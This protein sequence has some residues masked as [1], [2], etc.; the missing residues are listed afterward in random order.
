[1]RV[2]IAPDKFKGSLTA[3]EAAGAMEHGVR[4][5]CA[6][7]GVEV[8]IDVCPMADGGDGT[9]EVVQS[10][11]SMSERVAAR[12]T[13]P[14]PGH[15]ADVEWLRW[16]DETGRR[17]GLVE[18]AKIVGLARVPEEHRDP[19]RLST[20]GIGEV[21]RQMAESAC[22][23]ITVALGGTATIDGGVGMAAGLGARFFAGGMLQT[24]PVGADLLSIDRV[25]W[26]WSSFAERGVRVVALV[27][28]E[29]PLCG[30]DGAARTFGPQKGA[31]DQQI[32]Q[33]DSGLARFQELLLRAGAVE[34]ASRARRGAAGGLALGLE[35]FCGAELESGALCVGRM[36][37]L[38]FRANVADVVITGEGRL[39]RQTSRGKVA[40]VVAQAAARSGRP[41]LCVAG[42]IEA[43]AE[44]LFAHACSLLSVSPSAERAMNH[45]PKYARLAAE[46]AMGAW[47][48][49]GR[50]RDG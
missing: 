18:V 8:E 20:F 50:L 31:T 37:G 10:L 24:R 7:R 5:A 32:T 23:V 2:L 33:L 1:M 45:A 40:A 28:V 21:I 12:V 34:S 17:C 42:E 29:N 35:A 25:K 47:L 9:L 39:D 36:V 19:E 3:L 15:S 38:E 14:L 44:D 48:D 46:R 30:G 22:S 6:A 43:E 4:D 41:T 26:D 16:T 13:E 11:I 27:D 49:A